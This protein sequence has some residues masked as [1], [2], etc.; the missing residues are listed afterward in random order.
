MN[1]SIFIKFNNC[2]SSNIT[3]TNN[4]NSTNNKTMVKTND[5]KITP[6]VTTKNAGNQIKNEVSKNK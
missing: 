5:V 4:N 2:Y 6:K 1:S 3:V